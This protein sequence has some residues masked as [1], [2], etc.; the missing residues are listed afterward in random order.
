ML[1]AMTKAGHS[2]ADALSE[3]IDNAFDF[4]AKGVRL[5]WKDNALQCVDDGKGSEK[6][7]PFFRLGESIGPRDRLGRHGVGLKDAAL[8]AAGDLKGSMLVESVHSGRFI[9]AVYNW[10]MI[11]KRNSWPKDPADFEAFE[12]KVSEPAATIKEGTRITFTY[13]SRRIREIEKLIAELAWRFSPGL[14][15]GKQIKL[16]VH[17]KA[18]TVP[19]FRPPIFEEEIRDRI[20][21]RDRDVDIHIGLL[22]EGV[23]NERPGVYLAVKHRVICPLPDVAMGMS[24][25]GIHGVVA[26]GSE[27]CLNRNKTAIEDDDLDLIRAAVFDRC[28]ALFEKAR[29]RS[30]SVVTEALNSE[31]AT[32]LSNVFVRQKERRDPSDQPDIGTVKP[33]NTGVVRNPKKTQDGKGRPRGFVINWEPMGEDVPVGKVDEGKQV[34]VTLNESDSNVRMQREHGRAD[35]LAI[36]AGMLVV[37]HKNCHAGNEAVWFPCDWTTSRRLMAKIIA[38]AANTQESTSIA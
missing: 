6:V 15:M 5:L 18:R 26:L 8:W 7:M 9:S 35:M 38:A 31:I 3:L 36:I 11:A 22:G 34:V 33:S 10:A 14:K 28:Q 17:G 20:I 23:L 25:R 13:V 21:V 37:Q 29:T 16:T 4:D 30:Q 1:R 32:L 27:W 2:W 12:C 19:V 24:I